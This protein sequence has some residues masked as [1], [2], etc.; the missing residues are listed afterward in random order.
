MIGALTMEEGRGESQLTPAEPDGQSVA[1][2]DGED[3]PA[4][5]RIIDLDEGRPSARPARGSD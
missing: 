3:P 5:E 1:D 4:I 2:F